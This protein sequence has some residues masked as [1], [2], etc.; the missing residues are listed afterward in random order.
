MNPLKLKIDIEATHLQKNQNL[1][2]KMSNQRNDRLREVLFK[3][4]D[5]TES[6]ES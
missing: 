6:I 5:R 3:Y 4:N 1:V 2:L